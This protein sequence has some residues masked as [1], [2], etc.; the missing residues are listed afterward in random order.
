[1]KN[2]RTKVGTLIPHGGAVPI[3]EDERELA[4][5][6]L[7]STLDAATTTFIPQGI[8]R[9]SVV[10]RCRICA[11]VY[12]RGRF[13]SRMSATLAQSHRLVS[14]PETSQTVL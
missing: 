6:E 11:G 12:S 5:S 13:S 2:R 10:D 14:F 9:R 7:S 4:F 1:M 8:W 3:G